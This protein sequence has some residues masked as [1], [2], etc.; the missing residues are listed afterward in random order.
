M[1]VGVEGLLGL[2][3]VDEDEEV[4]GLSVRVPED[5]THGAF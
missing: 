4:S 2:N 1:T 5:R 3:A